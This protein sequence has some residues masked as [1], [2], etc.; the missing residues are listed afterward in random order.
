M[1]YLGEAAYLDA[2]LL[3]RR[4]CLVLLRVDV[5]ADVIRVVMASLAATPVPLLEGATQ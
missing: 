2:Y 3:T 4:Q 5:A 1:T